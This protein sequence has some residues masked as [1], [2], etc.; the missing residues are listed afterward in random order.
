MHPPVLVGR[1]REWAQ[2]EAA[3]EARRPVFVFG[4]RGMGKSRLMADFAQARGQW[5]QLEAMPSDQETLWAT[6]LRNG[7]KLMELRRKDGRPPPPDWIMEQ[8]QALHPEL[9]AGRGALR[10]RP[11]DRLRFFEAAAE[12]FADTCRDIPTVV[13][14]NGQYIDRAS[15]ELGAH[16]HNTLLGRSSYP[17]ILSGWRK[18]AMDVRHLNQIGEA[19]GLEKVAVV[20]LSPLSTQDVEAMLRSMEVP[21][22]D[23]RRVREL[24]AFTGGNPLFVVEMVKL[25]LEAGWPDGMAP[26]SLPRAE[27]VKHVIRERLRALS[28]AA[29]DVAR[30]V[31]VARADVALDVVAQVLDVPPMR[32]AE[33]Y[34]ELES[35]GILAGGWFT[36]DL[37]G[38]VL[39]EEVPG[40]LKLS[41]QQALARHFPPGR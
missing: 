32:L 15:Y 4:E 22:L 33:P 34:R 14:D 1:E 30:V 10:G 24:A 17:L 36:H 37:L 20:D 13:F 8:L 16:I 40:Q 19:A 31:A 21:G 28:R 12:L 23:D 2:I 3:W 26:S 5:L 18:S 27:P 7:R 39:L 6:D 35:R 11:M 25:M 29:R 38:E 9:G 41:L